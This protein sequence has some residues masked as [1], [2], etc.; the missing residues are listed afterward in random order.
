MRKIAGTLIIF[1][2]V[3]CAQ[4]HTESVELVLSMNQDTQILVNAEIADD[5]LERQK[6]LMFR[7]QLAENDGMIFIFDDEEPRSFWM[8]N[9]F[10]P[11]D[12]L[13]FDS[14]GLLVSALTMEPC[15]ADP[16]KGYPSKNPAKYVLEV[17][18][19]F[20]EQHNIQPGKVR[21]TPLM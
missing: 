8:K 10:I 13:Y 4:P 1:F 16:C 20:I 11:L 5:P 14:N 18:K 21:I 3:G 19:G 15:I 7:D 12:I 6:G 17:N 9:T 2:L